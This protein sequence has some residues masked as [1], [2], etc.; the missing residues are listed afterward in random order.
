MQKTVCRL[1]GINRE[2]KHEHCWAP[3]PLLG[4]TGEQFQQEEK[5]RGKA[6]YEDKPETKGGV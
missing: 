6:G 5:G 1:L 2:G 4:C 3:V